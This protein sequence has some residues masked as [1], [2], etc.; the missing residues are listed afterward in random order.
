MSSY[1]NETLGKDTFGIPE[2]Y[3]LIAG[4]LLTM[5]SACIA[6]V[7]LIVWKK[8]QENKTHFSV[9]NLYAS[10]FGMPLT[11]FLASS[12]EIQSVRARSEVLT[13]A[14]YWSLFYTVLS[15]FLG[16]LFNI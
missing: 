12:A 14:F 7:T 15:A 5:V 3:H 6:P 9:I 16:M 1:G 10:Y 11:L 2:S 13:P 4:F 8:A